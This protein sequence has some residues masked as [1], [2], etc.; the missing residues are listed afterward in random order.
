MLFA[1]FVSIQFIQTPEIINTILSYTLMITATYYTITGIIKFV[2]YGAQKI[3][4][5]RQKEESDADVSIID[6]F[7]KV[8]KAAIWIMAIFFILTNLGFE[9]T[10]MI[11]GLGI[12]GIAIAFA[13]QNVLGD[14][15]ASIS[16]YFDRPFKVGDYIIIGTDNGTVKHIGIKST[17]I[18]TLQGQELI[19][20]NKDLMESRIH[21]YKN[22]DK[23]RISFSFGVTYDT[24]SAKLKKIPVIVEKII[25]N[26]KSAE[27]DR[28]HFKEFGDSALLFD[29]VY[30]V[31]TRE[32]DVYMDIQQ[33]INLQIK[34]A[35][36]KEKIEMA[37]PTQTL[38]VHKE[39]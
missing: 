13:L 31:T 25:D 1:I 5:D 30:Y 16:I 9:I 39:K 10:P 17:R 2:D 20:S 21:N 14:V 18:Q 28:A 35:F 38:F 29:I 3:K 19:V 12:G 6:L 34:A 11:A 37:Y 7:S 36:E 33:A 8:I 27:F 22:M 26:A 15:F 32:Y 4:D 24:T 23:R